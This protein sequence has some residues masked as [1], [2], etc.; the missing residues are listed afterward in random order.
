MFANLARY[1]GLVAIVF[2]M[3][4]GAMLNAAI[5]VEVPTPDDEDYLTVPAV[6]FMAPP[7][8]NAGGYLAAACDCDCGP[9]C[10][11]VDCRCNE[12]TKSSQ[13][14]PARIAPARIAAAM[15]S[16]AVAAPRSPSTSV[17]AAPFADGTGGAADHS[18]TDRPRRR[19][20]PRRG[21][22]FRFE[23]STNATTATN[24]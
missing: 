20:L 15:P 19:L 17:K 2:W 24:C 5:A 23:A 4:V 7:Q 22:L 8:S 6:A 21:R 11:C 13:T 18:P 12:P 9:T 1:A 14:T 10:D 16:P 3:L